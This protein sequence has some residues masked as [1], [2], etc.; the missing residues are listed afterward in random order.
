[1][2]KRFRPRKSC[3]SIAIIAVEI[4]RKEGAP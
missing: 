4:N 3:G 1:L 2:D